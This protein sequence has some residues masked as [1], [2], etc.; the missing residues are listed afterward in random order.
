MGLVASI[1]VGYIVHLLGIL[2]SLFDIEG[3]YTAAAVA[4]A[5]VPTGCRGLDY[6]GKAIILNA[7]KTLNLMWETDNM[8]AKNESIAD[9]VGVRLTFTSLM[10]CGYQ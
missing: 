2:L 4:R 6:G 8:N 9:I 10:E 7:M 1:K 5:G 3:G